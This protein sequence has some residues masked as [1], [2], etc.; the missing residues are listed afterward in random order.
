MIICVNNNKGGVLKTTTVTNLAGVLATQ[1][2][3]VL[4][5]DA[6]NQSNVLLSFGHNPDDV[7]TSLYDVLVHGLPP[8][9]A[10]MSVHKYIDV[11]PSNRDLIS[12][13]F[14]ILGNIGEYPE[15]FHIMKNALLH[16]IAIYDYILIDTP[17]SLSL[18]NGNV[19][20]F[21]DKVLIPFAPEFFSMR[22]LIEVVDT[23]KDFKE[24][25]NHK[26]EILGVV[27]TRVNSVTNIHADIMQETRKY[28]YENNLHVFETMIPNVIEFENAVSY[29]MKPATLLK[30]S[31]RDKANLYFDLWKEIEYQLER[32]VVK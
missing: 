7:R 12:F 32:N 27:A 13:E 30:K 4:I 22:S 26:L 17:P 8:E 21:A 9:D 11:L 19:F 10:I 28:S 18:M 16:L 23:I 31:K 29:F 3:K 5:V 1:K 20:T 6:D 25:H 15:P 24:Q 2:K 14:D